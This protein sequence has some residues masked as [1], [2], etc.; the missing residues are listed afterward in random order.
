MAATVTER[1]LVKPVGPTH[2]SVNV[3]DVFVSGADISVPAVALVPLQ[4]SEAEHELEFDED[5][6]KR[7]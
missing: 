7:T 6:L 5:Q 4:E 2:S 3:L 1:L